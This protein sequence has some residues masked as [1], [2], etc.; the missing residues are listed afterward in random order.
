MSSEQYLNT[1]IDNSDHLGV[2]RHIRA[3][4]LRE[5]D[6][7][8][9]HGS[10]LLGGDLN[11]STIATNNN[12]LSQQRP[13][14]SSSILTSLFSRIDDSERLATLEQ[15][16]IAA[17]DTNRHSTATAV[18]FA[19]RALTQIQELV[20]K[21]SVRYRRLLALCLEREED[22]AG[23]LKIYDDLLENNP[24]NIYALRRKY[25][26]LRSRQ[27]LTG[28]NN[29]NSDGAAME[30]KQ[31]LND[32]LER[33]GSD[34]SAWAEM[35]KISAEV[36][37]YTGAAYAAEEVVLS[38]PLN[39]EA[40]CTLGEWYATVGGKE[41]LKLA[42]KHLAQ[43]LELDPGNVRAMFALVNTT[44]SY[45]EDAEA[46]NRG[47]SRKK[48]KSGAIDEEGDLEMTKDLSS[49]AVEMLSKSYKGTKMSRLVEKVLGEM[50]Q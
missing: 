48:K 2:L 45:L 14:S 13:S 8:L 23:A 25:C 9:H 20:G 50:D 37:D 41:N 11:I 19:E 21:E 5:P 34:T 29:N 31:A 26:I 46:S 43:S 40:H 38:S 10:L 30:V 49:L 39:S 33:N 15:L 3:H 44:E 12:K 1:L 18:A 4:K 7:V 32:Y 6:L 27:H 35:S 17:I 24:S 16:T 22:W 42:R 36:G 47:G 28:D